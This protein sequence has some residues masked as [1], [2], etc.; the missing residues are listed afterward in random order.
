[1]FTKERMRW[2]YRMCLQTVIR[3]ICSLNN[4]S[5]EDLITEDCNLIFVYYEFSEY[6]KC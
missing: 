4:V 5:V 1:M 3:V 2:G 6:H